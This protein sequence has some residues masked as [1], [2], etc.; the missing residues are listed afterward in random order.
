MAKKLL[1]KEAF[2]KEASKI[3][4]KHKIQKPIFLHSHP[5]FVNIQLV[6]GIFAAIFLIVFI[7]L[8]A[9]EIKLLSGAPSIILA[10]IALAPIIALCIFAFLF[11]YKKKLRKEISYLKSK[12]PLELLKPGKL[13]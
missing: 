8:I 3:T 4:L 7:W 13:R 10:S 6:L 12:Y 11:F 9:L 2:K 5:F 1:K